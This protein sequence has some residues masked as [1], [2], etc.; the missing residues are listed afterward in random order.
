MAVADAAT[1]TAAA[2]RPGRAVPY[3]L[4]K[5]QKYL[6]RSPPY[7]MSHPLL[8]MGGRQELPKALV[9]SQRYQGGKNPIHHWAQ[10]GC[11]K[12]NF[13]AR[14]EGNS[15]FTNPCSDFEICQNQA[16]VPTFCQLHKIIAILA[17]L[18]NPKQ[19]KRKGRTIL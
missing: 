4:H 3:L 15:L 12:C 5:G 1:A 13:A 10:S 7:E 9:W 2:G 19:R 18:T 6:L 8:P 14:F 11:L 17:I 16:K